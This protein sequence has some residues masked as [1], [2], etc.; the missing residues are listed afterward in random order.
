MSWNNV[1][2]RFSLTGI[3][4]REIRSVC[5]DVRYDRERHFVKVRQTKEYEKLMAE[6]PVLKAQG[7]VLLSFFNIDYHLSIAPITE[8]LMSNPTKTFK[9]T[10]TE[11]K[12]K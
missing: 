7:H 12:K 11:I 5:N 3:L 8:V 2:R 1:A 9:L 6:K 10:L 4:A